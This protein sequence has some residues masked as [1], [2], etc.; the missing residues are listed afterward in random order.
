ML[1]GLRA[2]AINSPTLF[3]CSGRS[4]PAADPPRIARLTFEGRETTVE[5]QFEI[6]K[7]ALVED[8]G[9]KLFSF[10]GELLLARGIAGEQV[11]EL[12]T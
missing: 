2:C 5:D 8:N 7:L 6:A 4:Q 12:T 11:L 1:R 10:R 3:A 9:W